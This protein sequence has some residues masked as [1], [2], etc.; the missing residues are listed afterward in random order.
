MVKYVFGW[1]Y[2]NDFGLPFYDNCRLKICTTESLPDRIRKHLNL[3]R[4]FI[5]LSYVK[6]VFCKFLKII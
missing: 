6:Y 5:N 1:F 4:F 3:I 2:R